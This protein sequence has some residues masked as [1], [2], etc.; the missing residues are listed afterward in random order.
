[1]TKGYSKVDGLSW[2][3]TIVSIAPPFLLWPSYIQKHKTF[4]IR[5]G[6][7]LKATQSLGVCLRQGVLALVRG[8]LEQSRPIE[9]SDPMAVEYLKCG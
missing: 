4:E 6:V 1:M 2:F 7:V 9:V 5:L 3:F 8:I